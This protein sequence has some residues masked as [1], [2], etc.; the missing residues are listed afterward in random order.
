MLKRKE[1]QQR[2]DE[3]QGL[4]TLFQVDIRKKKIVLK[5]QHEAAVISRSS[6]EQGGL[7]GYETHEEIRPENASKMDLDH[8]IERKSLGANE[9]FSCQAQ[10]SNAEINQVEAR[11]TSA[12]RNCLKSECGESDTVGPD[13]G[14]LT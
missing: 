9:I 5:Q 1:K 10:S 6:N 14:F 11:C 13:I 8:D 4:Q 7:D 2:Q 3:K 12:S